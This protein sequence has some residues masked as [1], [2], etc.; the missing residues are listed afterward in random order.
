MSE[1][2][3]VTVQWSMLAPVLTLVVVACVLLLVAATPARRGPLPYLLALGGLGAACGSL[4]A[5]AE[6]PMQLS[7]FGD[8][9]VVDRSA[10]YMSGIVLLAALLAV[11]LSRQYLERAPAPAAEYYA[12]L[13]MASLGMIVM[14]ST[15]NLLVIFL[16]LE[17]L[18]VALYVL[19]G[20]TRDWIRSLEAALKYFLLGAFST[21]FILYGMA[22]LYGA[23]GSLDLLAISQR[24][25]DLMAGAEGEGAAPMLLVGLGLIIVGLAFK[26]AAVPFHWWAPD[27]Y[28][29]SPTPV[30]A[31]MAVGTKAVSFLVL[32]RVVTTAFGTILVAEWTLVLGILAL[33][34]MLVGNLVALVQRNI[35]RMLAFSSV[36]HA[37]Y[38]LIAVAAG[39]DL[40][41]SAMMFYFAAYVLTTLGAFG[42]AS[43]VAETTDG[44]DEG[45]GLMRYAGLARTHP[46]LAAAMMIFM[47]SLIGVPPTAGFIGKYYIFQAAIQKAL[48]GSTLFLVLSVVGILLSVVSAAYYLRVIVTMY[49]TQPEGEPAQV[50]TS[51]DAGFAILVAA[52]GIMYLGFFPSAIYD[53]TRSLHSTLQ[54]LAALWLV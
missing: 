5:L 20:I 8:M 48:E 16:G 10:M 29:G 13:L 19:S 34:S 11:L 31:F 45:Y 3:A 46:G 23:T 9:L 49:M 37:G 41:T 28:E 50:R 39:T 38:L 1:L 2:Q 22:F 53:L 32:L 33:L 25:G 54:S 24:A 35:K 52:V 15:N 26:V 51:P 30:T 27:V 17:I 4:L 40:G 47:L 21:G 36:A 44:G 42:V 43:L 18:S 6:R 7:A 12:L 14:G